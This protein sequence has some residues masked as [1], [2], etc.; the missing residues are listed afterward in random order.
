MGAV[1]RATHVILPR[2]AAIKILRT[3]MLG[4]ATAS[5]R[6]VQE[7][8]ICE[9]IARPEVVRVYD[10]GLLSDGRSWVAMELLD[11]ETLGDRL[12][13]RGALRLG[14][15]ARILAAVADVLAEAHRRQILHRDIKPDNIMLLG[16]RGAPRVK[17]IDWG[18]ARVAKLQRLTQTHMTMGTPA[19]MSPEQLRGLEL[20]GRSDVYAL[21]VVAFE[22]LAGTL[23]FDADTSID[24]AMQHLHRQA[25][26]IAVR[27]PSLPNN[28]DALITSML[29][30]QPAERPSIDRVRSELWRIAIAAADHDDEPEI[31][32]E[33]D[34]DL[35][36]LCEAP[37]GD[38]RRGDVVQ[39]SSSA[40]AGEITSH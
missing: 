30:K 35:D 5:A 16:D 27:I 40:V 26:H 21:G 2:R 15:A 17:L 14:E 31:T 7:A 9:L 25:P 11:G 37:R 4:H 23:P 12:H 20:D 29:K 22:M 10:A 24:I 39:M 6:M 18:I 33:I 36:D 13:S 19:Y 32:V 38:L 1:Y 28:V 8:R 34:I 3:D